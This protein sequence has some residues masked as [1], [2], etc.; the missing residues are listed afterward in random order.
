MFAKHLH[1]MVSADERKIKH[2]K[3]PNSLISDIDH[4]SKKRKIGITFLTPYSLPYYLWV[5]D[6]VMVSF[7]WSTTSSFFSYWIPWKSGDT[8]VARMC[9]Q[10]D[11]IQFN[12]NIKANNNNNNKYHKWKM[13]LWFC[14]CVLWWKDNR[15]KHNI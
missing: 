10:R 2:V 13:N 4:N 7:I 9:A 1:A 11:Q 8:V 14:H 6:M 15:T 3:R 5:L 12:G